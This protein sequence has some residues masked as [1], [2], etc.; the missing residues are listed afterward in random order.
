MEKILVLRGGALGDFI[1]TLPA[2]AL[3]RRR[4]PA[5]RIELVG[6]A[7]AAQLALSPPAANPRPA[8]STP[9]PNPKPNTECHL[10]DDTRFGDRFVGKSFSPVLDAVHSQHAARWSALYSAATLPAEFADWLGTFDLVVNYWPDPD[11]SLRAKFPCRPGQIFL[12]A[13]ALPSRAP[14]AA[15]YCALL[16]ELG[17]VM[18]DYFY[19]LELGGVA[20]NA[21]IFRTCADEERRVKYNPPYLAIHPGSGS[22]NKNWPLERWQA[23][24]AWLRAEHRAELLIITGEADSRAGDVLARYGQRAHCLPLLDVAAKLAECRL[25]LGHDSG[26]SHLAAACGV[27]CVLLFGPTNPAMWAPPVPHVRVVKNR[28]ALDSIS[29]EKTQATVSAALAD[30]T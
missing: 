7:T 28:S 8:L 15:H 6:N 25:F 12:S 5:A 2:L 19:R 13:D 3:L 18:Q 10:L 21:E 26:V 4:W 30:R 24:C 11:G 9:P 20:P 14:A 16:S 27:P 1:V 17:L 22:P 29:L 23:L